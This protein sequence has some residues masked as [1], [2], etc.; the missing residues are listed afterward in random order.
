[1]EELHTDSHFLS[2]SVC[3]LLEASLNLQEPYLSNG[4]SCPGPA[5]SEG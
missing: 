1:M 2:Q 3:V 4:P 5:T